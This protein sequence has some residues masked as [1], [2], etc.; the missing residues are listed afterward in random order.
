MSVWC[1]TVHVTFTLS[2]LCVSKIGPYYL[3]FHGLDQEYV[4]HTF[5]RNICRERGLMAN[6]STTTIARVSHVESPILGS[7]ILMQ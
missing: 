2:L 1:R 4:T 3:S 5:L 6:R 7:W